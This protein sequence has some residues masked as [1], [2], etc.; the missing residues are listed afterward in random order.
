M[1]SQDYLSFIYVF[2]LWVLQFIVYIILN[3][4]SFPQLL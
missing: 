3:Y 4:K 2:I 1:T